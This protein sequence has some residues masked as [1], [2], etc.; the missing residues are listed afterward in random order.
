MARA[1]RA[2]SPSRLPSQHAYPNVTR[3]PWLQTILATVLAFMMFAG[4]SS[5][6]MLADLDRQVKGAVID[7]GNLGAVEE[8]DPFPTDNFE[9]RPVN[10]LVSGID[11]RYGENEAVGA[12]STEDDNTIRSDS[13][14]IVHLSA[15][16]SR[17]TVLSVPRDLMVEI[18][19]CVVADGSVMSAQYAQFNW[20]FSTGAVTDDLAGGIACVEATVEE[21]TGLSIDGFII[22]DFAGFEKLIDAMGGVDLCID[23]DMSD[24]LAG[25]ELTEGCHRLTGVQGLAF[26]RA[27]HNVGDGSDLQRIDRQQQLIGAMVA[28]ALN[29]SL[30]SNMP[31]MYQFVQE[32]MQVAA[33][34]RSLDTWRANSALLNSVRHTPPE[35]FQFVTMPWQYNPDDPNRVILEEPLAS[36]LSLSLVNDEP[37]PVGIIFRNLENQTFVVGPDGAPIMI[38]AEGNPVTVDEN[39]QVVPAPVTPDAPAADLAANEWE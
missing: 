6:L 28:Q 19:E 12:G 38:D 22:I 27:R 33:F 23:E 30:F 14:M 11:S 8:N 21:L 20:A 26:A 1:S 7:T 5:A 4:V 9:G 13:T 10:I 31:Q 32:A 35:N 36:E 39:G 3:F 17:T 18:P 29:S 16:R 24:E 37:L 15:D 34:S 2:V 25:L